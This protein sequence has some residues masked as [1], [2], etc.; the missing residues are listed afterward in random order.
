MKC[1]NILSKYGILFGKRVVGKG[2]QG[3]VYEG[4]YN[5]EKAAIK[6]LDKGADN[7]SELNILSMLSHPNIVQIYKIIYP[8]EGEKDIIL[9]MQLAEKSLS[10]EEMGNYSEKE[11][12]DMVYQ[13][14]HAVRYL[15]RNGIL[16]RDIKPGNIVIGEDQ[17][18][19]IIDF[20][21]AL[22][23]KSAT[24]L[25]P[26]D[27]RYGTKSYQP[28][29][30]T[31]Y[32]YLDD[33][34]KRSEENIVYP[35]SFSADIW[36]LCLTIIFI[37]GGK[38][39]LKSAKNVY[40]SSLH[41]T[42]REGHGDILRNLK[43]KGVSRQTLKK[44]EYIITHSLLKTPK[45]RIEAD[46]LFL[47]VI[48]P[49][50]EDIDY[51]VDTISVDPNY[52][53]Y[54]WQIAETKK[55]VASYVEF[56]KKNSFAQKM[57]LPTFFL[58]IDVIY[59]Y[60]FEFYRAKM[61]QRTLTKEQKNIIF[62]TVIYMISGYS[63]TSNNL[64]KKKIRVN[65]PEMVKDIE[66]KVLDIAKALN[67]S[68]YRLFIYDEAEDINDL[69]K[70][71]NEYVTDPKKYYQKTVTDATDPLLYDDDSFFKWSIAGFLNFE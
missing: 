6:F 27:W 44:L 8:P 26:C 42:T 22:I 7:I 55:I 21:S 49:D 60:M 23:A 1:K 20:G 71:Y 58:G 35:L 29:E 37:F 54:Q 9:V 13:L 56:F 3:E 68:I 33:E 67:S 41:Y 59:R 19:Q 46:K 62:T 18:I 45:D 50:Y 65:H 63:F 10:N 17:K 28:P 52:S 39:L 34:E 14:I 24:Y 30:I 4:F 70:M 66:M 64:V 69:V 43:E 25:Y 16:H 36:S 57:T 48:P 15:H 40:K 47:G 12:W 38:S 5:G 32:Y 51:P 31:E 61:N 2:G 53:P 11:K